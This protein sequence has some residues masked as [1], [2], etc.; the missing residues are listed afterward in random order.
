MTVQDI[1]ILIPSHSLEDF[2]TDQGEQ[3]A[4]G[5]LNAF[6]VAWHPQLVAQAGQLPRWHR[7]DEPPEPQP[8][9]LV[10]AP[11]VSNG[12]MPCDWIE[13]ARAAGATVISGVTT[14]DEVQAAALAGLEPLALDDDLVRDCHSLGL[15]WILVELLSRQMRN[16]GNIDELRLQNRAVGASRAI[17]AHDRATAEAHLQAAF[18]IL[19]EARER[20]Y[21][22]ECYL[23]DLCL[24][25]PD[26]IGDALLRAIQD[27]QPVSL[28]LSGTDL[29][30]IAQDRPDIAAALKEAVAMGRV[31]IIGGEDCER[32]LPL[33]PL[34]SVL[35]EFRRGQALFRDTLGTTPKVWGRRKF[36]L[37]P[38]LPQILSRW[39]YRGALHVVLDDGIYPDTEHSR[40]RWQGVDESKLDAFSRIPLATEGAPSF[41]RFPARMSES[42]DND[43]VA[44]VAFARWPEVTAPWL[45]DFRRTQKYAAPLGKFITFEQLFAAAGSPGKLC[46]YSAK[47]YFTPYLIQHVARREADPISRYAAHTLRRR[48]F[49]AA[50]WCRAATALLTRQPVACDEETVLESALEAAGPDHTADVDVAGLEQQLAAAEQ[51]WSQ[52]LGQLLTGQPATAQPGFLAINPFAFARRVTLPLPDLASPPAVGGVIKAVDFDSQHPAARHVTVDL[53]GC[54]FAWIPAHSPSTSVA[55]TAK[56]TSASQPWTLSN[57]R[58]EITLNEATGGILQVRH[59][60]RRENRFSQMLS[61]RFPRER[62][63]TAADEAGSRTIKSQYAEPQCE[64]HEV[65]ATGGAI[66]SAVTWG[67]I[68]DQ[69]NQD[70]LAR[71]RQTV[72]LFRLRPI[73]E[74][75]IELS[76]VKLVDGDPWNNYFCSRFAWDDSA[77]TVTRTHLDGAHGFAGERFESSEY[78]EFAT[79]NERTTLV[80]HGLPFHRKTGPRMVDTLLAA[81]GET[82]RRFRFTVAIDHSYPLEAARDSTGPVYVLPMAGPPRSGNTGWLFHLDARNVQLQRL[83]DVVDQ[84]A[85]DEDDPTSRSPGFAVRLVETEGRG[86]KVLL[87]CFRS[88]VFARKRDF[89]GQTIRELSLEGDAVAI[90]LAAYEIAEVELRF[91]Q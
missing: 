14:R 38:V 75:D 27:P 8:G 70:V 19:L 58:F 12:W 59:P 80:T 48:R 82:E 36:G 20:F 34:E 52:R 24:I 79:A 76:D 74:I 46:A 42:M 87:R 66:T 4:A 47:D 13:R 62:S 33:L 65:L 91:A 5:L 7:A 41:L 63:F 35:C 16:F 9:Q 57:E 30:R 84:P 44:A 60:Q 40:M 53:P 61:Y 73:I 43:H 64:G 1:I 26:V 83:L 37:T 28:I 3:P 21:P 81:W 77:A 49:D 6:A 51:S 54:G 89:Q 18:E 15:S 55:S 11:E 31:S 25:I 29:Q 67:R 68:V 32:P 71:F 10:F 45:E 23:L 17:V 72:R 39:G 78:L 22:V 56:K 86:R 69:T 50:N 88:P 2:P 90:D 85:S